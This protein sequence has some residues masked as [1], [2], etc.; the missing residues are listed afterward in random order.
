LLQIMWIG[1]AVVIVTAALRSRRSPRAA[2]VGQLAVAALFIGAGALVNAVFL[3]TG[4]TYAKFADGAYVPFVR[5][6]WRTLVVPNH[7][8]FI[9]L[10]IAF[11][12]LVGVLM[13]IGGKRAQLGLAGAIAFHVGL[14]SF[15][16]GFYLWSIPMIGALALLLRAERTREPAHASSTEAVSQAPDTRTLASSRAGITVDLSWIPLGAGGHIVRWN[17]IVYETIS[18]LSQHRPRCDIYHAALT[19]RTTQ[20]LYVVEMTP[21]PDRRGSER[22]VV[23]EGSV[24]ARWAG[25]LRLFRYEVRRWRDGE[26]PDLQYATAEFRVTEDP[27][28]AQR[29]FDVLPAVP[30][31]TWG[32]D[33]LHTGEMW[34]CNSVISWAL[35]QAGLDTA[36]IALPALGRAPGWDAGIAVAKREGVASRLSQVA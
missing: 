25:R 31:A 3:A 21:I 23:A 17:G 35:T 27:T 12:L 29:V 33:E 13:L 30:T 6:T 15:G 36:A 24:G 14:L 32:R 9:S 7:Y 11:E 26:I 5:N 20:G 18:A 8:A 34:T 10:L 1:C 22:G 2:R 4:E 16:W 28:I 19:I